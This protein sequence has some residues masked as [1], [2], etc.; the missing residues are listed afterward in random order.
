LVLISYKNENSALIE[1][2]SVTRHG[3]VKH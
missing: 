1:H 3:C 2:E